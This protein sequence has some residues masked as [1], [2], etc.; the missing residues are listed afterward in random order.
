M[1]KKCWSCSAVFAVA[2]QLQQKQ[3]AT[4]AECLLYVTAR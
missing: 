3:A 1:V 4:N 2:E